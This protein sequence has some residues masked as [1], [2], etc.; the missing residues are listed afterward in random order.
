MHHEVHQILQ[1]ER[2]PK[3]LRRAAPEDRGRGDDTSAGAPRPLGGRQTQ[4]TPDGDFLV[5]A[6]TGAAARKAYRCPGCQQQIPVGTPHLV[7]WPADDLSWL[8]NGGGEQA[9]LAPL[10]LAP[11]VH[12]GRPGAAQLRWSTSSQAARNSARTAVSASS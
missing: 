8:A 3:S 2:P 12:Q 11:S 7:V 4:H 10:V 5:T 6:V 9:S 1:V